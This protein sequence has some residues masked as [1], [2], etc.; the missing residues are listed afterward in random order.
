[1][2]EPRIH[3]PIVLG[4]DFG[5]IKFGHI[6]PNSTYAG[7]LIR[8]GHPG[9]ASEHYTMLMS[10]G[11]MKGGTINRCPGVY[12]VHCGEVPVNDVSYMLNAATG[13][14]V[15]RAPKGRVRIEARNIDLKAT[16]PNNKSGHI[17]I[18][19]NEPQKA[20]KDIRR[21]S[22]TINRARSLFFSFIFFILLTT[23]ATTT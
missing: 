3:N 12:Q 17:N 1:M 8:N 16:G 4:N 20:S 19:S 14:I 10:S 11:K 5:H 7:V 22:Q 9:Q 21:A 13:D 18:E 2:A 23:T 6:N 15:L